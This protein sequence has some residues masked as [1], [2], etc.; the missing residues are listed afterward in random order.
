MAKKIADK[1]I[2]GGA[3]AS[4]P[5]TFEPFACDG[6]IVQVI[7]KETGKL[8]NHKYLVDGSTVYEYAE[9]RKELGI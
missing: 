6:N 4:P 1:K 5:P 7:Y 3:T 8:P 2:K 9:D